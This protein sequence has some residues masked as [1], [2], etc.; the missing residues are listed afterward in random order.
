MKFTTALLTLSLI[1]GLLSSPVRA[2][3]LYI[4]EQGF[5][6]ENTIQVTSD[7]QATWKALV[8]D[9]NQWWPDEHTWWGKA[10]N[11]SIQPVAGGCFCEKSGSKSA[12][13]MRISFVSPGELLRMT[14]GLGPLQG[15]GMYGVLDWAL[16]DTAQGTQVTLSYTV[17]GI[18]PGG[19]EELTPV[20]D[21]VQ[22]LQ[23]GGLK[24][25]LQR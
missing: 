19:Y 16:S 14:G 8:E 5:K 7:R 4:G 13:H 2:E 1:P 10:E 18:N 22:A 11:L 20:V 9:V 17:S 23:L 24:D 3:V 15:M 6:I 12:E 21:Q 25:F